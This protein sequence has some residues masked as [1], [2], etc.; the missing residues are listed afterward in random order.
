MISLYAA[1]IACAL[2]LCVSSG[3]I[4]LTHR[5][6]VA[7]DASA[8]RG[9]GRVQ[10]GDIGVFYA[11]FPVMI[12]F[13]FAEG[14]DSGW[15]GTC[16]PLFACMAIIHAT[17]S[18]AETSDRFRAVVRAVVAA[19]LC[20]I[21][22]RF[23]AAWIPFFGYVAFP[24]W[25][26]WALTV[27]WVIVSMRAMDS[28]EGTEGLRGGVALIF[29]CSYAIL[30][31][32][33]GDGLTSLLAFSMVGALCAFLF[34]NFPPA[35]ISMGHSG[36]S[37]TGFIV[38]LLPLLCRFGENGATSIPVGATMLIV[39]LVGATAEALKDRRRV[40]G[41]TSIR[42]SEWIRALGGFGLGDAESLVIVYGVCLA[43]GAAAIVVAL[44][45]GPSSFALTCA[46][47]LAVAIGSIAIGL[48]PGR[49]RGSSSE[50]R[51]I[52]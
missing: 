50:R 25:A 41:S 52:G 5:R 28:L 13:S 6:R 3:F 9:P 30:A 18:Y 23:R 20:Y 15:I 33:N 49:R 7:G 14:G 51:T 12:A 10:Y 11:A 29:C 36:G 31:S 35:R 16:L 24:V 39:P 8:R 43:S 4:F 1:I 45:D 40:G 47:W 19:V 44:Q 42:N 38:A 26:S 21:D 17:S 46:Y 22:L 27:A 48:F 37:F 34:N 2:N 32:L